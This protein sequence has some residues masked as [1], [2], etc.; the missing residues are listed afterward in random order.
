MFYSIIL[1]FFLVIIAS[2][3]VYKKVN[4][5]FIEIDTLKEKISDIRK[6]LL[7]KEVS[8]KN[9]KIVRTL[10]EENPVSSIS[11]LELDSQDIKG[12][13]KESSNYSNIGLPEYFNFKVILDQLD[14]LITQEISYYYNSDKKSRPE[15]INSINYKLLSNKDGKYDWR[16]F[17]LIHP[18]IYIDLINSISKK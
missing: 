1:F 18:A 5:F 10:I 4:K 8:K 17:E 3:V 6:I 16:P 15:N 9:I 12:Y 13:F 14:T 2:F 11:I 7:K